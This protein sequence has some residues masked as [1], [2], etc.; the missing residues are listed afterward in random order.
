M[1]DHLKEGLEKYISYVKSK[2]AYGVMEKQQIARTNIELIE[3]NDTKVDTK[4]LVKNNSYH[5]LYNKVYFK[6]A[7]KYLVA[8]ERLKQKDIKNIRYKLF[9]IK[10]ITK[11]FGNSIDVFYNGTKIPYNEIRVALYDFCFVVELPIKYR[12]HITLNVLLRP[13]VYDEIFTSN[14]I[15][16]NKADINQ[17]DDNDDFFSM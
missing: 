14:D 15:I 3:L 1:K 6:V 16:I 17:I 11:M 8:G 7:A 10:E 2:F 5:D 9:T 13:Y 4:L 12:N